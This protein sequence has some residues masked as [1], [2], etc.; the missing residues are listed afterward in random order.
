MNEI[1]GAG[2]ANVLHTQDPP[3]EWSPINEDQINSYI[4][5][6][7]TRHGGNVQLAFADLRDQRDQPA[8]YYNSNLAIA[9][10]YLRARW[11]VEQHGSQAESLE[12]STYLALKQTTGVPKEGPGPVSPYSSTEAKYMWQGIHDQVHNESFWDDAKWDIP[13]TLLPVPITLGDVKAGFDEIKS[14]F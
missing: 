12:V 7:M 14:L 13:V 6:A 10:D 11:G 9:A 8:N 3:P 5:Q 1:S 2:F 4:Q